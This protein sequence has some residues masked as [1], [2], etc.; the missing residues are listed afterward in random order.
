MKF[1]IY[2]TSDR[3]RENPPCEDAKLVRAGSVV[4]DAVYEIE[5][6]TLEQ[7]L[8]LVNKE[9][10]VIIMNSDKSKTGYEY[11]IEIYDGYRE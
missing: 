1:E 11:E 4:Q 5:I 10:D 8:E 7:L 6:D 2:R 3:C 9:G